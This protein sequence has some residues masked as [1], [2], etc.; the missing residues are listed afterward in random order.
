M[1]KCRSGKCLG[2][3]WNGRWVDWVEQDYFKISKDAFDPSSMLAIGKPVAESVEMVTYFHKIGML[4]Y[5]GIGAG[6]A[7]RM[8]FWVA[9][10]EKGTQLFSAFKE[11]IQGARFTPYEHV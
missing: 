7:E 10:D 1:A 5:P 4:W 8:D 2:G 6:Y 3:P 9:D 11:T